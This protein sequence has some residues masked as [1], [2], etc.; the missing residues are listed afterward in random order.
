[1]EAGAAGT[2]VMGELMRA[3]NPEAIVRALIEAITS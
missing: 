3:A 1:M 2:A